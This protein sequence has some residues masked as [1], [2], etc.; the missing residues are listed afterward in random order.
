MNRFDE[1]TMKLLDGAIREPE[2][3]ELAAHAR[4]V[5]GRK[6]FLE[7]VQLESHLQSIGRS[8]IAGEV[9]TFLEEQRCRRVEDGVMRTVGDASEPSCSN[10]Q[11]V[12]RGKSYRLTVAIMGVAALA[13]CLLFAVV[14]YDGIEGSGNEDS[15]RT[16][17]Q[18]STHGAT[19]SITDA[20][21]VT[22]LDLRTDQPI[23]LRQNETVETS[24]GI[25]SAEIVY[26]DGTTI[27]LL[28]ETIVT[29]SETT[30]GSKQL[31]VLSGVIQA[32]V[33]PQLAGRPLRIITSTATLEVLGTTLGVE[34]RDAS[35]QLEVATGIV[36]MTRKVDNQRVEVKAGQITTATDSA[37]H[38]L[39]ARP[40]PELP[41][42]WS[43][44]FHSGLP[45]GWLVG[46]L[47]DIED[48]HAVR[49]TF[50]EHGSEMKY[51]VSTQNAWGEGDHGLFLLHEDSVLHVRYRQDDVAPLHLM[52][53]T[54]AYPPGQ[55]RRGVNL[56][57]E[58]PLRDDRQTAGNWQTLSVALAD[59]SFFD[60]RRVFE[61]GAPKISG[62][63]AFSLRLTTMDHDAGLIVDRIW[64][65][66]NSTNKHNIQ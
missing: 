27:E 37:E 25:D 20:D 64:V 60:R 44:D 15:H 56:H 45:K 38:P 33:S 12:G 16:I 9:V 29:L 49:A 21:G 8:S 59:V 58:I 31:T 23:R 19:L 34:V 41:S 57:Y 14:R 65:T 43:E 48:G 4:T 7:L 3:Q 30:N 6:A 54:R 51:S 28:G 42:A 47:I 63:A 2:L 17:A 13:A 40:F 50:D 55:L 36:A 61:R 18:V 35:T 11:E 1:L 62:L 53:V 26:S 22:R 10:A 5:E 46:E 66:I 32:D 52:V 24:S 39:H